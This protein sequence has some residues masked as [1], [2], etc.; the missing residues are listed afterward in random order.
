METEQRNPRLVKRGE[1]VRPKDQDFDEVVRSV[2][3]VLHLANGMD[4]VY[5]TDE[6]VDV[7]LD[8]DPGLTELD[9]VDE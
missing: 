3:V 4:V 9:E 2:S 1:V 7:V 8:P 5:R 6:K